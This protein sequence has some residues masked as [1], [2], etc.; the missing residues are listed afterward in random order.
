VTEEEGTG[1][2]IRSN[3][4]LNSIPQCPY[5]ITDWEMLTALKI[6]IS[7]ELHL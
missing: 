3:Q 7:K 1:E 2:Y 5:A 4:I 6:G